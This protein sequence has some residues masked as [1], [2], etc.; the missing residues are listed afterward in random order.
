MNEF[1]NW[2]RRRR[3]T[4]EGRRRGQAGSRRPAAAGAGLDWN[5][6]PPKQREKGGAQPNGSTDAT[7]TVSYF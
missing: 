4:G 2:R 7:P 1:V 6:W 5:G 3:R